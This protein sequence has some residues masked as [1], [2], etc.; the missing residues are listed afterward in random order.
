MTERNPQLYADNADKMVV[1]IAEMLRTRHAWQVGPGTVLGGA[2]HLFGRLGQIIIN[3]M[4]EIPEQHFRAF[5]NEAEI[6]ALP[7]HPARAEI[8]FLPAADG[9]AEIPVPVGTQVATRPSG[10]LPALIYETERAI[11]VTPAGLV[12]CIAV[13][14]INYSDHTAVAQGETLESFSVFVGE[15]ERERILY[16]GEI[17]RDDPAGDLMLAFP[18]AVDRQSV[19]LSLIFEPQPPIDETQATVEP[20]AEADRW[21]L[22]WLYWN[23][24]TWADL[25]ASGAGITPN[26]HWFDGCGASMTPSRVD[27]TRL[28][29]LEPTAVNGVTARWLAVQLTGGATRTCLPTLKDIRIERTIRVIDAQPAQVNAAFAAIQGGK[30]YVPLDLNSPFQPLGPQPGALDTFYLR[31][32]EAL[33][34]EGA[35]VTVNLTIPALPGK[36]DDASELEKLKIVWE[37]YGADGWTELGF[38]RRGC[39]ELEHMNFDLTQFPKPRLERNFFTRQKYLEFAVPPK[40]RFSLGPEFADELDAGQLST[41]L[42]EQ[43]QGQG[44]ALT[45]RAQATVKQPGSRWTIVDAGKMY[46]IQS[47]NQALKV[48]APDVD[49]LPP[50]FDAGKEVTDIYTGARYVQFPVPEEC[51][52]L[53]DDLLI[54]GCYTPILAGASFRDKTCALTTA[55]IVQFRVPRRNESNPL[56]RTIVNGQEGYWVRA[57]LAEGSYNVPRSIRQFPFGPRVELPPD[58]YAPVI[59]QVSVSFADYEIKQGP[60][61]VELCYGKTDQ[62]WLDLR[63][64]LVRGR[65]V[66]PFTSSVEQQALY[67][68][69]LPLDPTSTRPAFPAGAWLE[70][71]IDVTESVAMD[72]APD[73]AHEYWNGK[74][75][76]PLRTIDGT[77]GLKRTGYLGFYAPTDH[78]PIS[79]FGQQAYWLRVIPQGVASSTA[80]QLRRILLNTVPAVNAESISAE[81]LGSSDG[82]KHQRFTFARAPVL[83]DVQIE[84]LERD[85]QDQERVNGASP[86]G[87]ART[88]RADH[89][90]WVIWQRV[91]SF[92]G[93]GPESR[94]Y[95]LDQANGA[96][97]FGD[98]KA[99][100]IPPPGLDNIRAARYRTHQGGAG[101]V[102]PRAITELRSTQGPLANVDRVLNREA[103]G[104]GYDTEAIERVK[105]RGPQV[106]KHR[107]RA[108]AQEDYQWLALEAQGVARVYPLATTNARGEFQPGWVTLVIV[109]A[110]TQGRLEKQPTPSRAL[111][112]QV[113]QYVEA[114]ALANLSDADV[115]IDGLSLRGPDYVEVSVAAT[116]VT[117]HP[118]QADAVKLAVIERLDAFLH[119]LTGGPDRTG[120]VLGRDV[121]V[122]EI[123][124]EIESVAGVDHVVSINLSAP[125]MQTWQVTLEDADARY[126]LP[127]G[128]QISLIDERVKLIVAEPITRRVALG[129]LAVYGFKVGDAAWVMGLPNGAPPVAVRIA[130]IDPTKDL[131]AFTTPLDLLPL[132]TPGLSIQASDQRIQLPILAWQTETGDD[133]VVRIVGAGVRHFAKGDRVSLVHADDRGRLQYPLIVKDVSGGVGLKRIF[134][135]ASY[136]VC[137]GNHSVEASLENNDGDPAA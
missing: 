35:T 126:E 135:P 57:R 6:D 110:P 16:I 115:T 128:S 21:R 37:Y 73:V 19:T 122:S 53:S 114:R 86:R 89:A 94:C 99:G 7:P 9:P 90:A 60:A 58:V 105:R 15:I 61:R 5:L 103:A 95:V 121:Y 70:L 113:R 96:I 62:R 125:S 52:D 98:G 40:Y 77:L 127:A 24:K 31:M 44:E 29:D 46:F 26:L 102:L 59:A 42:R 124:S 18:A 67:L 137:S 39:P 33:S 92:Y 83:P 28:P 131:L 118:E 48:Y 78:Q 8:T 82:E 41:R 4:N 111:L 123:A 75:W 23:G 134:A 129:R 64:D 2:V 109:P 30:V 80:P 34:K 120:W 56:A 108:V 71:H 100:K 93:A 79:E 32:D 84:V 65:P 106:L 55:G 136:L 97:L 47:E 133:G 50:P 14:P 104:G 112:H 66:Q 117:T 20:P 27:F 101:N 132:A 130:S 81:I 54:N 10:D 36:L 76:Q 22:R 91:E 45:S 116:I 69:F 25:A 85:A 107:G 1:K 51:K 12:K 38:S 63:S 3:R 72:A 49:A 74:A 87:Q 68:G 13:D 88:D 119:P 17:P 43:F 11:M